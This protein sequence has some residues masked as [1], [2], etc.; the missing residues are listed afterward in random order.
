MPPVVRHLVLDNEA[1]NAL[2]AEGGANAKRAQVVEAL[3][4]ANGRKIVPTAVRVEA[5]WD[6]KAASAANANRLGPADLP[7]DRDAADRA[8]QLRLDVVQASVVD[9]TVAAAGE[10]VGADGNVVEILTSDEPDM[11]ALA[12]HVTARFDIRRL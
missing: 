11:A 4:A 3:A 10:A 6:R 2:L 1:V 8:T 12:A 5:G 9:A 7:L